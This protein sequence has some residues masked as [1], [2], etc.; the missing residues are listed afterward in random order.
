MCVV[1]TQDA[2][3]RQFAHSRA[4]FGVSHGRRTLGVVERCEQV[5]AVTPYPVYDAL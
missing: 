5:R 2:S 1:G 3:D 4:T